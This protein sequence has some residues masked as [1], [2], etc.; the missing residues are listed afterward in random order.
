MLYIDGVGTTQVTVTLYEKATINNP[1]FT[2]WV[3]R[4]GSL[5]TIIFT[6][7]DISLAPYYFNQFNITIASQSVGLTQ[8]V[9]PLTPGEWKYTIYQQDTPYVLATS[10]VI[11]EQGL[12]IVD[13][14]FSTPTYYNNDNPSVSPAIK[15]YRG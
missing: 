11:L 8:G 2:W 7:D 6:Q 3:Q 9:V 4:K 15:V 12:I 13:G 10:S 1:Y 14:T 5:D